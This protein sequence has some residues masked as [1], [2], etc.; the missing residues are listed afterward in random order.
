MSDVPRPPGLSFLE[1]IGS[2]GFGV[3][4]RAVEAEL[5]R[6][7][8]VKMLRREAGSDPETLARF[9]SEA[10]ITGNLQHP[11]I[12]PIHRFGRD[13]EGREFFT[14]R[15]LEG[16]TLQSVLDALKK[17]DPAA[18][19][20]FPLPRLLQIFTAVCDALAY[21]HARGVLHRDLKP[22][23]LMV[24]TFGE[25]TVMDWGLARMSCEKQPPP[26]KA[27]DPAGFRDRLRS[28]GGL[29][30]DGTTV[31]T[32]GYMAP[33]QVTGE[34]DAAMPAAD[35]YSLGVLLYE[36]LCLRLPVAGRSVEELLKA[37]V[38]GRLRPAKAARPGRPVPP[39]LGAVA[40]KALA[41]RP[42]DRYRDVATLARDVRRWLE[43][44][45]LSVYPDGPLRR[46]LRW[47]RRNRVASATMAAAGATSLFATLVILAVLGRNARVEA[48]LAGGKT[49]AEAT[50]RREAE[51]RLKIEQGERE[52]LQRRAEASRSFALGQERLGRGKANRLFLQEAVK[53]FGAALTLDPGFIE[54]WFGRAQAE[55]ELS[56]YDEALRD[57]LRGNELTKQLTGRESAEMLQRAGMITYY[58]EDP[59]AAEG[60]F[61]RAAL[62]DPKNAHA[63]I[64]AGA[65][66]HMK[67]KSDEAIA[68]LKETCR[69]FPEFWEAH[70]A[71]A[72]VYLGAQ[73]KKL[74]DLSGG[75][76]GLRDP[77]AALAALDQALRCN[78][79]YPPLYVLRGMARTMLALRSRQDPRLIEETLTDY[80]LAAALDP[81]NLNAHLI[82][83]QGHLA[84][85]GLP[86]P[87]PKRD[88]LRI[89]EEEGGIAKRMHPEDADVDFWRARVFALQGRRAE[90][91]AAVQEALRR[92]PGH[93]EAL[94]LKAILEGR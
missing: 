69:D 76:A 37:T 36:L 63:R 27:G 57:L 23:N 22:S 56:L 13:A 44:R 2:G 83:L 71:L 1:Q 87:K 77:A 41:L 58:R 31:G 21:A 54:A 11:N 25:I 20:E 82:R 62:A 4:W 90:A 50:A 15:V 94:K 8:A 53:D 18:E 45:E 67:G 93:A 70:H 66:L 28:L 16:R 9:R 48:D 84:V 49:R 85:F 75:P 79:G 55:E 60:Y 14:M 46:V 51:A 61:G 3:V 26:K 43:D 40:R 32:P 12:V 47:A 64:A 38:D 78:P 19:E 80:D 6:V 42:R 88:Y 33:E 24:G 91:L 68:S 89:A 30:M 10:V 34:E 7:V 39:A 65:L 74:M 81:G 72:S 35:L 86:E 29:T 73:P 17:N 52:R 92:A 5:D 59:A